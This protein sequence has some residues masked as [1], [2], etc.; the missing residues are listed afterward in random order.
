MQEII[1]RLQ[2]KDRDRLGAVRC[3]S[4]LEAAEDGTYIWLRGINETNINNEIK[5]LPVKSTYYINENNEL[6]HPGMLTPV[7][8]LKSLQWL[9]L[10]KF[11]SVEAPISAMPGVVKEKIN[12]AIVVS[13][14]ERKG[15]ALLTSLSV[16]KRYAETA[17][18]SRLEAITFVVSEKNEVLIMGNPLP[19]LPGKEFWETQ[20]VLIPCGYDFQVSMMPFFI[21][22][23][24]NKQKKYIILFN[25]DSEWQRIEKGYFVQGKRSAV[26]LTKFHHD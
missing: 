13:S 11:I 21:N 2:L 15:T 16:W 9:P 22:K 26:R 6:F 5:R 1:L 4:G 7:D 3:I 17:S 24:W 23:A 10:Q 8:I 19:S 20:D 12:I 25:T 18:A 14:K